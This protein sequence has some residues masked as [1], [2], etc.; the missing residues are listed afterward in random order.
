MMLMLA[1]GTCNTIVMKVQDETVV[2]EANGKVKVFN[3]PFFQAANMFVGELMCLFVYF[4]RRAFTKS[5][6]S[7]EPGDDFDSEEAIPVSPG[8][9]LAQKTQLK[10]KINPLYLAVP[11]TF[12]F[13]GSTL[14]FVALTQCAASVYQMMRG[15]IVV[16]TSAMAVIFLGKKQY[17]H[18]ITSLGVI[19]I[20]VAIV[21]LV[22]VIHSQAKADA[23]GGE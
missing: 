18:H 16:I 17:I 14:M 9:K 3:H 15:F 2:G 22:G 11:A 23:E 21:G 4:L 6:R 8:T 20:A 13:V 7:G 19:V 1:F 12:D 5:K 10:T